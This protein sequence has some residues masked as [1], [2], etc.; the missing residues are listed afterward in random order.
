MTAPQEDEEDDYN[1]DDFEDYDED[2]EEDEDGEEPPPPPEPLAAP[3]SAKKAPW[4]LISL[5]ELDLGEQLARG[6]M[7]AVHAGYWRG[8]P[9][10]AKRLHDTSHAALAKIEQELLVHSD[11]RHPRV[12]TLHGAKLTPPGCCIVMERCE[13]SLFQRLHARG[14][15]DL[16]RRALVH[17]ALQVAQGM[18][19][20]HSRSPAVVHRDLKS[21]NVLI[22]LHGDC[23]LCDFGLVNMKEVTAGTPNYMAPELFLSKPYSTPVDVFA[24]GVL[25]NEMFAREVPWDGYGPMDIK[26]QVVGG[27]RPQVPRTMPRLCETLL[28]KLWHQQPSLRPKFEQVIGTLETVEESLPLGASL[29]CSRQYVDTLDSF[30]SVRLNRS[31]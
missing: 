27:E 7:G 24:F 3:I 1:D 14:G 23:K 21:H 6:A 19:F 9:V 13:C 31:I 16:E 29:Q 26:E 18:A 28:R 5:E 10:A 12:V 15:Q 11:L 25:L 2:F 20:L 4:A 30:A 17:M 22:D 8:M